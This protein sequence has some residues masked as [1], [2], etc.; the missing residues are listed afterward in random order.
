V[1]VPALIRLRAAL[2]CGVDR[3]PSWAGIE[4]DVA[5]QLRGH[6]AASPPQMRRIDSN[7]PR[8]VLNRIIQHEAVHAI[9]GLRDLRRRLAA[10]RRCYAL[11][12]EAMPDDPLVF[13][14]VALTRGMTGE[15]SAIL[16]C[17]S[18]VEDVEAADCAMF[19]SISSCH[20]G[21]RGVPF[22]NLL[23]RQVVSCLQ[24]ELPMIRTFATVSPV[25]G[26]RGW[27]DD[28]AQRSRGELADL[29]AR[30]D[31]GSWQERQTQAARLETELLPLC[32]SYLLHAKRGTEP[33]D[34]VARFHLANG[35]RLE[36]I[37]W[38]GDRSSA[39]FKR[40]A[41]IT[42]NYL[43]DLASVDANHDA[44]RAD[45]TI[46]AAPHVRRLAGEAVARTSSSEHHPMVLDPRV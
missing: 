11:F 31:E 30:L 27:L 8:I 20:D 36:R 16:D 29:V 24:A 34:A 43:Y 9:R 13:T 7:A 35:A 2:L 37:N 26:F 32:A 41:G 10:D 28:L 46:L 25:P 17:N 45:R 44:Y 12:C 6:F 15:V 23:I 42:A 14:E 39:G 22:G 1:D 4:A 33:L 19:Y 18:P 3:H 21:L 40:S 5:G 38:L